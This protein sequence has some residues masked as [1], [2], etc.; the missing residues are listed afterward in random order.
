MLHYYLRYRDGH[1][2]VESDVVPVPVDATMPGFIR[3]AP[4]IKDGSEITPAYVAGL[5]VECDGWDLTPGEKAKIKVDAQEW[6]SK[7]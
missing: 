2:N 1:L 4:E 3:A 5:A 7:R 6:I